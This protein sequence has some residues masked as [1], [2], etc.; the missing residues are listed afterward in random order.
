MSTLR[1]GILVLLATASLTCGGEPDGPDPNAVALV[2]ITPDT[3]SIDTGD[4]LQ[5]TAVARNA[6][7]TALSGKVFTWTTLDGTLVTV[8]GVGRVRGRWPGHARVVAASEGKADT[9]S[10]LVTAKIS[11]VVIVPGLDTVTS[12]FEE[13]PLRV[14]AFIDT[15]AYSGGS[16]TW[17]VSDP[18]IGTLFAFGPDSLRTFQSLANGTTFVRALE[19]GGARDSA[20]I[21]V[22][23]RVASILA[24][25]S[26]RAFRGCPVQLHALPVDAR[27]NTVPRAVL[28]WLSTDTTL[29]RVDSAG[30]VTPRVA[31]VDTIVISSEGVSRRVALV[32]AVAAT[33][34]LQASG[35]YAPVTTVGVGQ[36]GLG[37]GNVEPSFPYYLAPARF[38]VV[39][40]DTTI[41]KAVPADTEGYLTST[42][43]LAG[44]VRLVGR[45]VGSVTLTPYL[46]D[47]AGPSVSFPVTRAKVKLFS[48]LDSTARTDDPPVNLNV[49][50]QDSTGAVQF[51][52]VPLTVRNTAT[53]TTVIRPDSTY[54]HLP[55]GTDQTHMSFTFADSGRARIVLLDSSGVFLPDSSADVHVRYPPLYIFSDGGGE[56]DTLH[57][58][59]RQKPY[60]DVYRA[61]V[62]LDRFVTGAPLGVHVSTSD[63]TIV[64]VGPDSS[65]V[66]VGQSAT[67]GRFDIA[68]RDTRGT[69][70]FTAHAHRH[71]DDQVVIVV[72]RPALQVRAPLPDW[73]LYPGDLGQVQVFAAD[74]ASGAVGFPTES[75]TVVLTVSDTA[76]I[77]LDSATLTVPSGD[78]LSTLS[79]ITFKK[80]GTVTITAT[81]PRV[82]PY[83]YAPG[84]S[85]AFTIL[86]PYLIADSALSLG[87]EQTWGYGVYV[88]GNL[89]QG[90][91]VHLAH[92]SP[93]VATLRD[94]IRTS[95][96]IVFATGVAAGV[97]TVIATAPGFR[98]DTGTIVVGMGTIGLEYWPPNGLT[99][100]QSWSLQLYTLA[101]NGEYRSSTVT[102]QFT[103]TAN[104]NIEFIQ[105]GLPI[106]SVTVE[107]DQSS[108][109]FFVRGK[110]AGTG[111][112][113]ISAPNYTP[114][115]KSVTVAP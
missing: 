3:G 59:M 81:D 7:G 61:R 69:A 89:G 85:T 106:T 82:A 64:R 112:V 28:A 14:R 36:Y 101:P 54:R 56:A 57:L 88:N 30:L 60:Y 90:D 41:L 83:S 20:R 39:S 53:D 66:P 96:G 76:V 15:Q 102:K 71:A 105:D 37:F 2:I 94:T 31:G 43:L 48:T 11:R 99:V 42:T 87:I 9:A 24:A 51:T 45:A 32:I 109:P 18:A 73:A 27:N 35:A 98:A 50:T 68:A 8:S 26:N 23:Q 1:F 108:L 25:Q 95:S 62:G 13:L 4:S 10:V 47:A 93:A 91:V 86:E 58:G 74:S 5:L 52:A 77:S 21:V 46:C 92:R 84:T 97:D 12:L 80:P 75:V 70:I 79:F 29:A 111:T 19:A 114:L 40:S 100:G 33:P 55:V 115:T 65:E 34:T 38:R 104:G 113:T 107:P 44:P 110:A 103:L 67:A 63:S 16:Y 17:G 6:G 78:Y 49:R 22:R 72:G